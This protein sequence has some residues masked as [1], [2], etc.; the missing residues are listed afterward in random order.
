M[1][2]NPEKIKEL[3]L[4][5]SE[6]DEE[7]QNRLLKEAYKLQLMQTQKKQIIK[8]NAK[9][10]TDRDWIYSRQLNKTQR[11]AFPIIYLAMRYLQYVQWILYTIRRTQ[12]L[13]R[14]KKPF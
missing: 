2:I 11:A 12:Q 7:Y 9:Y 4:A 1:N 13:K 8:G 10:S 6:L 14:Q 5:Y 3:V